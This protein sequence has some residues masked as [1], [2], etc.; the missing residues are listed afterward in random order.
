LR[1]ASR[2][3]AFLQIKEILIALGGGERLIALL[4]CLAT[5]IG[6]VGLMKC[7]LALSLWRVCFV[8]D[9][10]AATQFAWTV[11]IGA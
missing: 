8:F 11:F 1:G 10:V 4:C 7:A 3:V 5:S 6:H 9:F 2:S